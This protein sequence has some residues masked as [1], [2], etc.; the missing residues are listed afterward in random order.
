MTETTYADF[1]SILHDAGWD[2]HEIDDAWQHHPNRERLLEAVLV[3]GER[4]LCAST[5]DYQ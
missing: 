4:D 1:A 2:Q 5:E 3:D